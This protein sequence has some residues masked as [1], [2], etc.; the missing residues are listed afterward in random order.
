MEELYNQF[1]SLPNSDF[2]QDKQNL[3]NIPDQVEDL[4]KKLNNTKKKTGFK[5]LSILKGPIIIIVRKGSK[6]YLAAVVR[7]IMA[8]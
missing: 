2:T 3:E 1:G 4:R 6:A 8:F 7:S 5:I